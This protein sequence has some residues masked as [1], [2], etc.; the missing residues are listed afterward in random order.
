MSRSMASLV[1]DSLGATRM[2]WSRSTRHVPT[3]R[4]SC[5]P[6]PGPTGSPGAAVPHD[7]RAPLVGDP[8]ARHRARRRP[9]RPPATSSTAAA[10]AAGVELD[11]PRRRGRGQHLDVVDVVDGP[12]RVDHAGAHA[13]GPHVDDEDAGSRPADLAERRRQAELARD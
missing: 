10:M 3:V 5:Q 9:G 8:H 2:P 11:E 12:V 6:I 7:G 1:A 4:R 13:R